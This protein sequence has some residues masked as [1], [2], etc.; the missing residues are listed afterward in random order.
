MVGALVAGVAVVAATSSGA[1]T[2][3]PRAALAH[4][5]LLSTCPGRNAED[6]EVLQGRYAYVEWIGCN[7]IGF[8]Q[9]S[10]DGTTFSPPITLPG[11]RATACTPTTCQDYAWDPSIAVSPSGKVY[12]AFM[13]Q[14][15][16]VAAPVV[17]VSTDRGVSFPQSVALPV[18]TSTDPHGN[19][20][21]RDYVAVDPHGNVYVTWDYGPSASDVKIVCPPSGSCSFSAGD[22]NIVVQKSTDGGK[23]WTTP[24]ALSGHFPTGGADAGP[25][26]VEPNGALD[27]LFNAMPT[28]PSTFALSPGQEWFTR[29]TNAGAS[30]T[31]PLKLSGTTGTESLSEWWIDGAISLDAA[32]DLYATWDTQTSSRDVAWLTYSTTHGRTWSKPRAVTPTSGDDAEELVEPAGV[33]RGLADV[34]WQTTVAGKGYETFL[35]PFSIA[36]GW[37]T[38]APLRVSGTTVGNP[39]VWPGDT[40]GLAALPLAKPTAHGLPVLVTWGSAPCV[41]ICPPGGNSE[42]FSVQA[43]P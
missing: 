23:T 2:P 19:F 4:F 22:L 24:L 36:K 3:T 28:N 35:R 1:S 33:G 38:K 34:A 13:Y 17:D 41:S 10:D 30:W 26:V 21:D 31:K 9:S 14:L 8:A 42:I 39:K 12:A 43:T 18:P 7:G 40:F 25:I 11:S 6:V 27:V 29:S 16:K 37:L 32:G 20:G 15:G 5:H